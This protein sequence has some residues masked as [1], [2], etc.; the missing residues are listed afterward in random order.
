ML[1]PAVLLGHR[2]P[3]GSPASFGTTL[4]GECRPLAAPSESPAAPPGSSARLRRLAASATVFC[5]GHRLDPDPPRPGRLAATCR[6]QADQQRPLRCN[7]GAKKEPGQC[8]PL[9]V[10][11]NPGRCDRRT[12]LRFLRTLRCHAPAA[13]DAKLSTHMLFLG[14]RPAALAR[15]VCGNRARSSPHSS[16]RRTG[17]A[18]GKWLSEESPNDNFCLGDDIGRWKDTPIAEGRGTGGARCAAPP[19]RIS[20]Q[21]VRQLL[22]APYCAF[23]ER[24]DN[25]PTPEQVR[26][27]L[28]FIE[29]PGLENALWPHLYWSFDMCDLTSA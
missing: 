7:A 11:C 19:A 27:P 9:A 23:L 25:N 21:H 29:E 26:C 13:D 24:H 17:D 2:T 1:L 10:Y 12:S 28:R 18:G 16:G 22:C 6:R 20:R 14:G 3:R 5:Q 15:P 8:A 4:A